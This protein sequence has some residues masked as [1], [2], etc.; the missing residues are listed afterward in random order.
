M[1]QRLLELL[2]QQ[3]DGVQQR[4]FELDAERRQLQAERAFWERSLTSP[5]DSPLTGA[6]AIAEWLRFGE[7]ADREVKILTEKDFLVETRIT[8]CRMELWALAERHKRLSEV[9]AR[10]QKHRRAMEERRATRQLL[11]RALA[12]QAAKEGER[13]SWP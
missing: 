7:K 11:E 2:E 1:I 13:G 6:D 10:R 9:F 8:Q 12:R 5:L 3:M 4:L